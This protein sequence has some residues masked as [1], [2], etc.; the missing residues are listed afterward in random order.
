M[1]Q[2][3]E[4]THSGEAASGGEEGDGMGAQCQNFPCP[5]PCGTRDCTG[6]CTTPDLFLLFLWSFFVS[7]TFIFLRLSHYI[8]QPGLGLAEI[9]LSQSP[10]N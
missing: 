4:W 10:R 8:A 2:R 7:F 3:T 9:L 5:F 1:Q 6:L